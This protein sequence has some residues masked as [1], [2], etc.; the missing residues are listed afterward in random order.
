MSYN[1]MIALKLSYYLYD[2]Y[3]YFDEKYLNVDT[4]KTDLNNLCVKYVDILI[5]KAKK[6]NFIW[7]YKDFNF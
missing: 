5:V 1:E 4:L 2:K 7:C 6:D 3:C